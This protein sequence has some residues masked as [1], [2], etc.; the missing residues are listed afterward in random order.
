MKK[1]YVA[2]AVLSTLLLPS[3]VFA[4]EA[5]VSGGVKLGV[6]GVDDA[7]GSAKFQ[8]YRDID[9][10]MFGKIWL[11]AFKGSYFFEVKGKNIGLDDQSYQLLG[12]KYG[13]FKYAF[14]YDETPH[15]YTFDAKTPFSGVGTNV[16]S[17]SGAAPPAVADWPNFD[18]SIK[19]KK[20]GGELEMSLS[21]PFYVNVGV[22][23]L[24]SKGVRPLF[25][26]D[27]TEAEVV[28]VPEP[29]DHTTNNFSIRTGYAAEN[30]MIEISGLLSSFDNENDYLAREKVDPAN[31]NTYWYNGLAPD[32]DYKKFGLK[33]SWKN[34]PY[35]SA[36]AA[37]ASY[38]SLEN[39]L[40]INPALLAANPGYTQ[41]F[42]GDITYTN[43]TAALSSRP[44]KQ[45]NT[46][47]YGSYVDKGNDA[48]FISTNQTN[49][50]D[51]FKY[52]KSNL[53]LEVGYRLPHQTKL[54]AGYDFTDINRHD[55]PEFSG[56]TDHLFSLK[57]KNT[58]LDYLS[59]TVQYAHLNRDYDTDTSMAANIGVSDFDANG[60]SMDEI[61]LDVEC[62][63]TDTLDVGIEYIYETN[64]YDQPVTIDPG[65]DPGIRARQKDDRN[66]LYLDFLWRL[67]QQI[68]LS[69]FAG[70]ENR[71]VE[72]QFE[73]GGSPYSQS[74]EDDLW[75]YGITGKMPLMKNKLKLIIDWQYQDSDG[76]SDFGIFTPALSNIDPVAD[77]TKQLLKAKAVY[78]FSE[79]LDIVLGYQYEKYEYRDLLYEGFIYDAS[80]QSTNVDEFYFSGAY[81]DPDY[82]V[83]L[84]YLMVKYGF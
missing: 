14:D 39:D 58:T 53:G 47:L 72:S 45:V 34:L 2:M 50:T 55:R 30:Y 41:N 76:E 63:P 52:D 57:V 73:N 18:F 36:F 9:D 20:Y 60:K 22:E 84:G 49:D 48:S 24:E 32:N 37:N 79:M 26:S 12:G 43:I 16:L 40:T 65:N 28:E 6:R 75:T 44:N 4:G 35:G 71:D 38:A 70:Y 10:G 62:Y 68:Q 81:A 15:N 74:V 67:P 83:N 59:A 17:Y 13:Q 77:Y 7:N 27:R 5:D 69:G 46:R 11:D 80:A 51:K 78:A 29:I 21:S 31:V 3:A 56:T 33:F 66:A 19:R 25:M 8:E 61:K 42:S 54:T 64:D 82:E 23:R 1:L